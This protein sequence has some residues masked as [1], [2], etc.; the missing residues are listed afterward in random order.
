MPCAPSSTLPPTGPGSGS[1]AGSGSSIRRSSRGA[2]PRAAE[3]LGAR[4]HEHTPVAACARAGRGVVLETANGS[5]RSEQALLAT[6]AF[7]SPLRPVRRRIVPVWDY[8]LVTEPLDA[9]HLAAIGWQRRQGVSDVANRFH[10]Y[11]LTADNR[12]LWG[13]YDA[14][15]HFGNGMARNERSARPRSPACAALLP[16]LPAA[17]GHPVHAP[18]GRPDRHVQPLLR[19]LRALARR[20]GRV[21]R[22]AHRP[23]HRREPLRRAR[24]ARPARGPRHRGDALEARAHA[25]GPFPARAAALGG[26]PGHAPGARARRP[27]PGAARPLAAIARPARFGLRQL[28]DRF[29]PTTMEGGSDEHHP[30][31]ISKALGTRKMGG[32]R[33]CRLCR[34]VHRRRRADRLR[35]ARFRRAPAGGDQVL[36]RLRQPRPRPRSAGG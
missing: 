15:Y 11:R 12:I 6:G 16:H 3:S 9:A 5:I 32:P 10:Y 25:P 27:A 28:G 19:L 17:R 29:A 35:G 23:R 31:P 7:P 34:A 20:P 36:G 24:G 21:R 33:R 22:R 14:I 13:G 4:L 30:T 26:D 1:A 8:V 18:L 2:S